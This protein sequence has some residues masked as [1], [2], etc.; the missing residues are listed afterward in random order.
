MKAGGS[1][2]VTLNDS[3]NVTLTTSGSDANTMVGTYTVGAE[4]VDTSALEIASYSVGITVDLSGK[5]TF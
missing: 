5:F 2:T 3:V 4:D 1:M